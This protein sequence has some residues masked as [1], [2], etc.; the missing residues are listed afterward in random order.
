[1]SHI[2]TV[3]TAITTVATTVTAADIP[4]ANA[5]TLAQKLVFF[6]ASISL[7]VVASTGWSRPTRRGWALSRRRRGARVRGLCYFAA[8]CYVSAVVAVEVDGGAFSGCGFSSRARFLLCMRRSPG[9]L[10]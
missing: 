10:R 1:M 7:E 6:P 5:R 8:D 3:K 4:V 2:I 9:R